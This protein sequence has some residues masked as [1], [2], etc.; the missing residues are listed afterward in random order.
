MDPASLSAGLVAGAVLLV[1]AVG[2]KL[3]G[4]TGP[5]WPMLGPGP[6]A[7]IGVSMIPRAEITLIIMQRGRHLGADVL[8]ERIYNGMIVVCAVTCLAAPAVLRR[9]LNRSSPAD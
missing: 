2:G 8:P 1:A 9:L 7:T 6:A 3:L 5:I 4:T